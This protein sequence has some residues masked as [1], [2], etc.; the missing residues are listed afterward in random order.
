MSDGPRSRPGLRTYWMAYAVLLIALS[1]VI[2]GFLGH[3]RYIEKRDM[4]R[5]QEAARAAARQ[6]ESQLQVYIA[7]LKGVRALF[8]A[9]DN[10]TFEELARYFRVLSVT[11][12]PRDEGLEGLGVVIAVPA[13]RRDAYEAGVARQIPGFSIQTSSTNDTL[14]PIV[15]LERFGQGLE[16]AALGWDIA[17]DEIRLDAIRRA[18]AGKP[19]VT[20]RTTLHYAKNTNYVEGFLIYL[21]IYRGQAGSPGGEGSLLAMVFAAF[22]SERVWRGLFA[23][24][25]ESIDIE[26]YDGDTLDPEVIL[27]DRDG[28]PH[29]KREG[30]GK[31]E[32]TVAMDIFGR[33]WT[34]LSYYHHQ[35][36]SFWE[37]GLPLLLLCLGV[38]SSMTLFGFVFFQISSR[39]TAERLNQ[40]LKT[41]E[42]AVRQAN[43]E[44][45]RKVV[46]AQA[47]ESRLAAE[48]ERLA[49]TLRSISD[50]VVTT[51]KDGRIVLMNPVAAQMSEISQ[52]DAVGQPVNTIFSLRD[53][54]E[55]SVRDTDFFP[56]R[57]AGPSASLKPSLMVTPGG[58]ERYVQKR[59]APIH[60][61]AGEEVG[62]V[63]VYRDVTQERKFEEE[64]LRASKLESLGLLAGGIAHDFNNV[65]TGIVGNLS[66]LKETPGL[67]GEV[68]ERLGLLEKTA[69]KARQL[70]LQ[71]LTFAKGGSPIK[72]TASIAEVLRESAEFALRGANIK[73][74]FAFPADLAPVEIDAGQMSQVVQNL[75]INSKQAMPAG[76]VIT[77]TAKNFELQPGADLPLPP[78]DYVRI[79]IRDTGCGIK[80]EHLD[81][82]F[83]PYFTTK[84]GGN[85]LGLATVYSIM[86]RHGGLIT[87][88]SEPGRGSEFHLYLPASKA[89]LKPPAAERP[90]QVKMAG[91]VLA[92]DD[93]PAIRQLL[94]QIL[95]HFGCRCTAVP[96]GAEALR[97]YGRAREAG[98]AY[99]CV[100]TDLTVPGGMGGAELIKHLRKMDPGVQAIVSS[101]YSNDPVLANFRE[102]GFVA[103]IDK[104]YRLNEVALV[105]KEVLEGKPALPV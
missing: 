51:D 99:Q 97:E 7:T 93:E 34:L 82:I 46:D 38:A 59:S 2:L 58:V 87:V 41:S 74:D 13:Q 96:D 103:R 60:D 95:A 68:A 83:D 10:V 101:G 78:G 12:L 8:S 43:E 27:F 29:A 84:P 89:R 15:Y 1:A 65:L 6:V 88:E 5:L 57:G 47:S 94:I 54:G 20:K 16:T 85:G 19:A 37:Q 80:R 35:S 42:L 91:R 61:G 22:D 9:S 70:T 33:R 30:L 3:R 55:R 24:V 102:H 81:R 40:S 28:T 73:A 100:I 98:E 17:Q 72:Q 63:I 92:M 14:Y 23:N 62:A 64:L 36:P 79:S 52:K 77:V 56:L 90:K 104:P 66:L 69:Y 76:G 11:D 67:P 21:P 71:L 32:T 53:E 75:I 49:V 105:L 39:E 31:R 4:T 86:K 18:S 45:A 44:L 48:K 50:A 26:I 25:R